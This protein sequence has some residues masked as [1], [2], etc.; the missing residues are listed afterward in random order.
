MASTKEAVIFIP[1]FSMK[2]KGYYLENYLAVGLT[3]RLEGRQIE[4]EGEEVKIAG[5]SG[6]RFSYESISGEQKHLDIY[7]TYWTD[8]VDKLSAHTVKDQITRGLFLFIY[9]LFSRIWTMATKSRL[10]FGQFLIGISL[11]VFWY[12]GNIAIGLTAIGQNPSAFGVQFL[13]TEWGQALAA[14]GKT[15]GGWPIWVGM[16][17]LLSFLPIPINTV[18]DVTDFTTRYLE[19]DAEVGTG[20]LRDR[21]RQRV[22]TALSDVIKEAEYERVTVLAHSMGVLV[23]IDLLGDY[24][25]KNSKPIRYISLGGPV[26]FA[27]YKAPWVMAETVKCLNNATVVTWE[28]YHSDQDWLCTKTPIPKS[29]NAAKFTS[30]RI[31]IRTSF[32]KQLSGEAHNAYFVERSL[33]ERLLDW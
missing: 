31:Q 28:D 21:I 15:L 25:P 8:L 3:T 32:A 11:L 26:E 17:L 12:Y 22:A 29:E 19:E 2:S 5:Q 27:S 1:G 13:P 10:L 7:E 20:V 24:H 18:V 14:L 33:L 23:G 4:L 6:R 30:Q 16:S 9:W